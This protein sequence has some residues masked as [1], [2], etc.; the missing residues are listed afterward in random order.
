MRATDA[1]QVEL[2]AVQEVRLSRKFLRNRLAIKGGGGRLRVCFVTGRGDLTLRPGTLEGAGIIGLK[3]Q[4]RALCAAGTPTAPGADGP[5]RGEICLLPPR[6]NP[7]P[8]KMKG[9]H[10]VIK[11]SPYHVPR[12]AE[13]Q[14]FEMDPV[15]VATTQPR[16]VH[17]LPMSGPRTG[18]ARRYPN[19]RSPRPFAGCDGHG[20]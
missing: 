11:Q 6:Q 15:A 16:Q 4:L 7:V 1:R 2:V 17:D 3:A 10:A 18:S 13:A 5:D 9:G 14:S 8:K 19:D 12:W 20:S